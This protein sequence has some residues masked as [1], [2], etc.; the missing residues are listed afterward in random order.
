MRFFSVP[1]TL[2]KTKIVPKRFEFCSN[3]RNK[4]DLVAKQ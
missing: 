2:M 1:Q 3:W 4:G